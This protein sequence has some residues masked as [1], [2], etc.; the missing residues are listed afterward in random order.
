MQILVKSKSSTRRALE[1]H[2]WYRTGEESPHHILL[3]PC[4]MACAAEGCASGLGTLA[5]CDDRA[6]AWATILGTAWGEDLLCYLFHTR[7][8]R[9]AA[10]VSVRTLVICSLQTES[11]QDAPARF[12]P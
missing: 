4:P 3:L 6:N 7:F 1:G 11:L 12:H 2:G 10:K 5:G 9:K 8:K